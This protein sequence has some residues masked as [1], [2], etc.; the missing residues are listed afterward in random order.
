M[1]AKDR[2][3]KPEKPSPDFPLFPHASGMWAKKIRGK[4]HYFGLWRDPEGALARYQAQAADLHA[5][6]RPR[7]D[8]ST[9]TVGVI[10]D[11]WLRGKEEAVKAGELSVAT[12][13]G[14]HRFTGAVLRTFGRGRRVDDLRPDDFAALRK[15]MAARWGPA[16]LAVAI[17]VIRGLFKFAQEGGLTPTLPPFG[18]QFRGPKR[19]V[20]RQH[21]AARGAKLFT[22]EEVL[23]M[24]DSAGTQLRAMILLGV[25]CGFGNSDCGKLPRSAVNPLT[26]WIDF[27]RPKTGVARRSPLWPE[28]V[29]AL[30]AAYK[31]RPRPKAKEYE[32]MYFL[33]IYGAPWGKVNGHSAIVREFTKLLR[34]LGIEGKGRGFYA[35]RHTHRTVADGA[36]DQ[37]AADLIMGHSRED[38]ASVYRETIADARLLE[39]SYHVRTWLFGDAVQ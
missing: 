12:F 26:A 32:H 11:A 38:M 6:R 37:P 17:T 28:T 10:V 30:L 27:P 35:L 14:Y 29:K 22:R 33:T 24:I 20:L 18:P 23:R 13:T 19:R 21:R 39:V 2:S 1:P 36:R 15:A 31:A 7:P 16:L 9:V 3:N 4:L 5:G 34:R 8:P 25:N